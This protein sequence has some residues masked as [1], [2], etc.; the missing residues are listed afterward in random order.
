MKR[1]SSRRI[2]LAALSLWL[3]LAAIPVSGPSLLPAGAQ[4]GVTLELVAQ[5]GG[6]THAV[7]TV[8]DYAY[9]GEGPRLVIVDISDSA[10]P[11]RQHRSRA[12]KNSLSGTR[13]R[14]RLRR[15]LSQKGS[16]MVC[17]A[18]MVD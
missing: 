15:G 10:S 18:R 1:T 2:A 5:L 8:G 12:S 16:A 4:D 13:L 9:I 6:T 3:M 11:T 14:E 7:Y 17:M